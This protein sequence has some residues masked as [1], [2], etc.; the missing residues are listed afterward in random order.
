M[1]DDSEHK[2][3]K[4]TKKWVIKRELIFENYKNCVLNDEIILK[5]QQAFRSDH[6]NAYTVEIDKVTLSSNDGKRLQNI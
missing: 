1:G 4:G 3:A 5:K 6:H 2:K